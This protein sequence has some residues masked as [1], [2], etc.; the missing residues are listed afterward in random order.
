LVSKQVN[1]MNQTMT[2]REQ[3]SAL[4]DGHLQGEAFARAIG[5]VCVEG[6]A[7]AAWHSYHVVGDV[8]RSGAHAPCSDSDAFLSRFQQRLAAEPMVAAPVLVP[9]VASKVLPVRR[10]ADAANEPVFRWKLVAGAASLVAVAAISWTW[11]ATELAVPSSGAQIAA[12]QQP[13]ANSVLAPPLPQPIA[14]RQHADADPRDGRQR[15]PAGHAARPAARPVARSAPAGRWRLAN[16]FG[17]PA[18]CHLRGAYALTAR[19]SSAFQ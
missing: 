14:R 17:L 13:A 6:D 3:V 15:Q 9:V 1:E 10:K 7:R 16:A 4:A 8:L 11:S 12:Q 5:A 19:P 2:V 18:Q